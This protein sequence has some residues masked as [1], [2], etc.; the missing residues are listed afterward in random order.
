M[1]PTHRV[2]VSGSPLLGGS[3]L[4]APQG[5][6]TRPDRADGESDGWQDG[7]ITQP[8]GGWEVGSWREGGDRVVEAGDIT[9]KEA[10][11]PPARAN[12]RVCRGRDAQWAG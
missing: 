12:T 1:R 3:W 5:D 2:R 8:A 4:A 7:P 10:T 11:W 6:T 9:R